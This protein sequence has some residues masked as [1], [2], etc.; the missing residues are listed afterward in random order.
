MSLNQQLAELFKSMAA[1]L[2]IRGEPV[3][4]AIA[5]SK[6]GRLLD[7]STI[8][9]RKAVAD[10]TLDEIAGIG[11]SSRKIIEDVVRTGRS[12]DF[13]SLRATVPE[14]LVGMLALP[15]LGPRTIALLW[16]ERG[17]TSIDDL[18]RAIE[19]G[20]L[21]GLKGVGAKKIEQIKQGLAMRDQAGRR[22]GIGEALPVAMAFVDRLRA[23]EQIQSAEPAGSLRRRRETVGDLD[24][25]CVLRPGASGQEVADRFVTFPEVAR[26][27][28]QGPAKASVMTTLGLQVDLRIV[29]ESSFGAALQYFTGSKDHNVRLR[30]LAQSRGLTLN[31]WGLF[32]EDDWNRARSG[33]KKDSD[34]AELHPASSANPLASRTEAD[35]YKALDL[36]YVEPELREDRGEIELA[37]QNKLPA[38]VDRSDI[39]GELHCHTTASDGTASIEEMARAALELGYGYIVITDHSK[40]QVIARGLDAK[41]LLKQIESIR[42]LDGS[43]R[44]MTLLVGSEVDILADGSLDYDDD[45]LQRLDFVIASPHNA[46]RQESDKATERILR[47]IDNKFV[48]VIGHPTGRLINQRAGLE[49]DWPRVFEASRASGTALE[50]NAAY[51]RLD[52]NDTT[53]RAAIEA[54][55]TLTIDTDAHSVSGLSEIHLGIDVARRA[56]ATRQNILN[57]GEVDAIRRWVAAKRDR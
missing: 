2:E 6:V 42:K 14:G 49:L 46:L 51:P 52:L 56:G 40:S 8:D 48:N 25:L 17:I 27:L 36:Q 12:E 13:E 44:G 37:S 30:S 50:I 53:A 28:G 57:C 55:V 7:D 45:L 41:R 4:K 18:S 34:H 32:R 23:L 39:R 5:F 9:L 29:P 38:L 20:K 54:G 43:I 47:A 21:D 1:I 22:L 3:F 10:G 31:E 15:G 26:V 35:I 19:A 24:I 16:K 33:S 11:K